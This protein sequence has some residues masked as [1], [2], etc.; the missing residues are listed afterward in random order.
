MTEE[1]SVEVVLATP[2]RQALLHILVPA[3]ATIAEAIQLSGIA[4]LFPE[5]N[6]DELA[7][8]VWGTVAERSTALKPGDRLELYRPLLEDPRDLRRN[9]AM[10]GGHMGK[11]VSG[12]E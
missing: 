7:V 5:L 11:G 1:L 10:Q 2:E 9:Y 3:G 6:I 8:G 4:G 12:K